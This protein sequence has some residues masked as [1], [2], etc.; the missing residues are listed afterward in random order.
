MGKSKPQEIQDALEDEKM[1]MFQTIRHFKTAWEKRQ[2]ER[3]EK[4]HFIC[5]FPS[6][7]SVASLRADVLV[8]CCFASC[9]SVASHRA[10]LLLLSV[11]T[12]CFDSYWSIALLHAD[13][14]DQLFKILLLCCFVPCLSVALLRAE[15]FLVMSNGKDYSEVSSPVDMCWS[16]A[17]NT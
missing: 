17:C 13:D 5:C 8:D 1:Q 3:G 2:W 14:A 12:I 15:R 6:C 7:G 10:S 9:W 4:K 11:Q 16:V